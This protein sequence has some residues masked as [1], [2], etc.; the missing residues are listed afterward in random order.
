[1]RAFVSKL[2]AAVIGAGLLVAAGQAA[3][4]NSGCAPPAPPTPPSNP[5]PPNMPCNSCGGGGHHGGGGGGGDTNVNVNVN[6]KASSSSS[7]SG[8]V[9]ANSGSGSTYYGGGYGNWSQTPGNVQSVGGLAVTTGEE[10]AMESYSESST[11]TRTTVLQASCIDDTGVP[12]PAS[13][14][15]P[16]RAVANAYSGE[17]YRCIAGTHM[18][19]TMADF[20]ACL[21]NAGG[22][23]GRDSASH[24]VESSYSRSESEHSSSGGY[25]HSA[26]YGQSGGY[27]HSEEHHE[28]HGSASGY[29]GAQGGAVCASNIDFSHINFDGG[30]TMTCQKG[31]ALWFQGGNLTCRP[32]I[33]ARQ[34]NERSLLRRFGVGLKVLTVTRTESITKQRQMAASAKTGYTSVMVFDGGVGGFVQ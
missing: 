4:C 10:G 33:P 27:A 3:A 20:G 7:S 32:Q 23:G 29:G 17:V 6:V 21:D 16:D 19:V 34:C 26:G 30:K 18:Q 14:V 1:M 15:F 28:E 8:N 22:F 31:D 12:H 9:F 2:V 11:F 5:S 25:G 13:Q 24:V